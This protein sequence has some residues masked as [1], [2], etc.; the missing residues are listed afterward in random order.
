MRLRAEKQVGFFWKYQI[1]WYSRKVGGQQR[2]AVN[3]EEPV[4]TLGLAT[5]APGGFSSESSPTSEDASRQN[6]SQP[7][8]R[9]TWRSQLCWG[10]FPRS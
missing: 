1:F 2:Q 5:A 4:E 9:R 10:S 3:D 8:P 7:W 6:V